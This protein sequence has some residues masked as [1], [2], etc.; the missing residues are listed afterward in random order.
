MYAFQHV[1]VFDC[2][3]CAGATLTSFVLALLFFTSELLVYKTLSLKSAL[4]PMIVA[5]MA[6]ADILSV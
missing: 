1:S 5:G 6:N 3:A 2:A 4:Q